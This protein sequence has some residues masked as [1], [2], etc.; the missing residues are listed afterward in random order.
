MTASVLDSLQIDP[1]ALQRSLTN[2]ASGATTMLAVS[3]K[4]GSGKDTVA[5]IVLTALGDNDAAHLSFATPLKSECDAI[6]A[7]L[8]YR[9]GPDT[10]KVIDNRVTA[11]AADSISEQFAIPADQAYTLIED[12]ISAVR[13]DEHLNARTRTPLMRFVLQYLGTNIRRA[14][15]EN[16]WVV[17]ALRPAVETTARG[18]SV[19]F[20][21]AR[22]PNEIATPQQIGCLGVRLDVSEE[23]QRQRLMARDGLIPDEASLRHE[24]EIALDDYEHFDVRVLNEKPLAE[25]VEEIVAAIRALG[26][27]SQG[28]VSA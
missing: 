3:G 26:G 10:F 9:F 18:Q 21:D 7:L 8:R 12:L 11:R 19:Y 2:I 23:I 20:T 14:Q 5:P 22:F 13:F 27:S 24:S 17:R 6:I 28:R 4:Q 15:D 16:Y 25:V 1:V